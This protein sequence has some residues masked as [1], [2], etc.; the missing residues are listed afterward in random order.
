MPVSPT[1]V[2]ALLERQEAI[3]AFRQIVR[4]IV[5]EGETEIWA[6]RVQGGTRENARVWEFLRRVK[7]QFFPVYECDEYE[8]VTWGIPL[9]RNAWDYDR[10]H[11]LE[12]PLGELLLFVICSYPYDDPG[13]RLPAL[14]LAER[15]VSRQVL[16]AI[17]ADGFTPT[18]LHARLDETP[19]AAAA[20]FA[21]WLW[22]Q[23]GT[24]FLDVAEE[25]ELIDAGWTCDI[26][27]DL[28]RQWQRA[29]AILDRIG[30]LVSWLEA[31]PADHFARLLDAALC[32][33]PHVRYLHERRLYASEITENGLTSIPSHFS[34]PDALLLGAA[35]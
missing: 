32:R 27:A 3:L 24:V 21:D 16:Q 8:Q 5:P 29:S 19:Y 7:G 22:G 34:A 11:A 23:T 1:S 33:D 20:E 18:E 4:E 30:Q 26:V 25:I 12:M 6:A 9:V 17:P 35:A 2:A 13:L 31:D 15:H 10:L 28:A 14:D